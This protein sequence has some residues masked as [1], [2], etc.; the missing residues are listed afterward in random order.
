MASS[1]REESEVT[2]RASPTDG[3]LRS[4]YDTAGF[5]DEAFERDASGAVVPRPHYS[6]LIAQISAMA[7]SELRR[8]AE[9]ANRSFLHRGV[10]FTVYSEGQNDAAERIL[11]FDPI[12]RILPAGEWAIVEAGLRQRIKALNSFVHDVYHGQE[13]LRDGI[14]PRRLVVL[15]RHFR[16]E[17]VGIDVP[18][19]QYVHVV[20]S[21]LI[22]GDDGRW[23][24]L[25]DNL[26]TPSGV[27]YVL[28]NR[29]IMTRTLPDWFAD[30]GVR[31]VDS[32]AEQLLDNL[33][34]L[35]P[36][37]AL[38]G[39]PGGPAVVVLTPGIYN[40]AYFEHAFLAQ[41]M[42][43]E[44]V[45]GR[46][47]FVLENRVYMRTTTGRRQVDVIYRRVDDAFMDPLAFR[48]DSVLA[49]AGLLS[50]IRSGRVALANALGPG[51][52]DDK[53][54]YTYVPRM[55]EFYL[56]E[57]AILNNVQTYMLRDPKQ[58]Q[59]VLNNL[60]N[61]VVK[62]V[63][64]SGGYG[65]LIGPASTAQEREAYKRRV[66][67]DPDNFIA[68]PTLALSTAPTLV[69]GEIAPRHVD[70]RPFVLSGKETSVIPGGLTR[71]ALREDSLVVNSSQGGGTKDTWVLER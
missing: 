12:P 1:A 34:G 8:A 65:M 24:V 10:T 36:R 57:H 17:V 25:E 9:L 49:V 62:E 60:H 53:A 35:S 20:G 66:M 52:A 63:Q 18:H 19:D 44:L 43:V 3:V 58:C 55:I 61:L 51:V 56:G 5:Y 31:S 6:E 22:R 16:R 39:A 2:E 4:G 13:I 64:G 54:M 30:L 40:S 42:G 7:G 59:H 26:R 28:A 45:E 33:I 15:A 50:V 70:L 71:V 41:Q 11:P 48:P 67:A 69:E 29:Q 38:P 32:Y 27:S 14:V 68:Q 23:L 46:D 47:L 21:D 37:R